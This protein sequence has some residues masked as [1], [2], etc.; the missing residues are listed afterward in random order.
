MAAYSRLLS[1]R[2]REGAVATMLGAGSPTC[3]CV[4][5]VIAVGQSA[6]DR[7]VMHKDK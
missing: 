4:S 7:T 5:R 2:W 3:A 1:G 6:A